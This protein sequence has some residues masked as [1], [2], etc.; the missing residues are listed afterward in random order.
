VL[1]ILIQ[2]GR[3]GG[4]AASLGGVG[5]ESLLG[6]RSATPIARGTYVL[7]GLFLFICMLLANLGG[8]GGSAETS[9]L[10]GVEVPAAPATDMAP[11]DSTPAPVAP[12]TEETGEDQPLGSGPDAIPEETAA[13]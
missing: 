6:A 8:P 12:S 9:L 5:G 7:L 13:E 2:S 11:E 4:L 10:D 3:G 1:A